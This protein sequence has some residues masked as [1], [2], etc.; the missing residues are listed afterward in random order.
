MVYMDEVF[1]YLPPVASPPSKL[2]LLTLLK[3]A[4]AFGVG[5]VLATQNPVDLDYKAL[6]NTG[7][8]FLGKLQTER[9]KAR[10]LDGIEGLASSID[11]ATLD[12]MLSGLPKRVFLMHNVH[13]AEP[14]IFETRWTL[15]YLRGPMSRE[16]LKLLGGAGGKDA[17]LAARP[18]TDRRSPATTS[19]NVSDVAASP[20]H[21]PAT[22]KPVL[23]A[24]I[25]E[26][27]LPATGAGAT[28]HVPVLYGAA[29]VQYV[30]AK[31]GIDQT[32]DLQAIAPFNDGA[33]PID[34]DNAEIVA[35][36]PDRLTAQPSAAAPTEYLPVPA[37]ALVA[38]SYV[39][40][41]KDFEQW[42]GRA[43]GQRL[44]TAPSLGLTSNA[45]ESERDFQIRVQ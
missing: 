7:T 18:T 19:G 3:Q 9:D 45:G 13:D 37:A 43:Q 4:R 31:K 11:R 40:W 25:S 41:Q 32:E 28:R 38:R 8:W 27:Y 6:S 36:T 12:R 33:V 34:W 39:T 20:Q 22:G 21:L 1:G 23:P 16:E 2:P 14:T 29:R 26:F 5:I 44:F 42:I 30:D 10:V 24:G 15:S 17:G 35:V